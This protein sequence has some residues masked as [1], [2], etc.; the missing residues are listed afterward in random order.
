MSFVAPSLPVVGGT[1][2]FA[3]EKLVLIRVTEQ[4]LLHRPRPPSR[5]TISSDN[6]LHES[7]N[8]TEDVVCFLGF[9]IGS[10]A[11]VTVV[12]MVIMR[13]CAKALIYISFG[14]TSVLIVGLTVYFGIQGELSFCLP[15]VAVVVLHHVD[16]RE[17]KHIC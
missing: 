8:I 5:V 2:F 3:D 13:T 7:F 16:E 12:F 10:G 17:C 1:P 9:L 11:F 6:S 14:I 15:T 4:E